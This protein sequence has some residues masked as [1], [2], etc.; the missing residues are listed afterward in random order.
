MR[1]LEA[2]HDFLPDHRAGSEIYTYHLSKALAARGHD[3]RIAFTE[4]RLERPQFEITAGVYDDLP[5]HEVVYNRHFDDIRDLYDD[6]RMDAPIG[7]ILDEVAPDVL[8]VQSLV[9][10]GLGL[11]RQA[12]ARRIPIVMTL[13]EYFAACPRGGLLLDQRGRLC[14]PIPFEECARCL[15]PY[16]IQRERY[17]DGPRGLGRGGFDE[18]GELRFF[19]RAA[20]TRMA[21][22]L[23][24]LS[25]ITTF[26]A[27]SNFLAQRLRG[28]GLDGE[29]IVVSD[30][31]F[32]PL[33]PPRRSPRQPGAPLR[34]GYLGTIADYKGVDVLVDAF[35]RLPAG[36]A[37]LVVH[38]AL[39]WFPDYVGRLR[40]A[41]RPG[42]GLELAGPLA[43]GD[44]PRFL[45]GL[46]ALVVPSIW[47]ENSPL[48]IHEAFQCG[49][50]VVT[51][52]LGGMRELVAAGGGLTF[53]RGDAGA[54][55]AVLGR[56]ATEP[57][58][59]ERLRSTIPAVKSIEA[60]AAAME[61]LFE[62]TRTR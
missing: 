22:K 19:A 3:V 20:E 56:L 42:S 27:P 60:D 2:I 51:S 8:H 39:D 26:V 33:T 52:D 53:A 36:A 35:A 48:T 38:G 54:L 18:L 30:Y 50:P 29:K 55:A 58:L 10:F 9:Y 17:P 16:P 21:T 31:G 13:H 23:D 7:A 57:G 43:A 1:I 41:I 61:H 12:A 28:L 46:D 37:T 40:A 59:L 34:L 62:R 32:P 47:F 45:A 4:K 11:I 44:A 49:V 25:P 15:A 6:R 14:D 5:F 24:G